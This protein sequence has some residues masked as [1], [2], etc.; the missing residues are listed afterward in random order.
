M[1][2]NADEQYDR[3]ILFVLDKIEKELR[4]SFENSNVIS[5]PILFY[6]IISDIFI[7]PLGEEQS[8][9]Q[10]LEGMDLYKIQGI[11]DEFEVGTDQSSKLYR[12]GIAFTLDINR[13]KF[14]EA[15]KEYRAKVKRWVTTQSSRDSSI[16]RYKLKQ[17]FK[18]KS[19]ALKVSGKSLD[20]LNILSDFR[21]HESKELKNA[22][23]SL[24]LTSLI[25]KLNKKIPVIGFTIDLH[26]KGFGYLKTQYILKYIAE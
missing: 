19:K 21:P 23:G 6:P 7:P 17:L 25:S 12:K 5:Y 18:N 15:Y 14:N 13:D 26:T 4:R 16:G 22:V 10:K 24:N 20:L 1:Y 9:I 8:L 11:P 2:I 3:Y